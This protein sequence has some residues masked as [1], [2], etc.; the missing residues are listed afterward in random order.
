FLPGDDGRRDRHR[1]RDD[2]LVRGGVAA[3]PRR[4]HR[5]RPGE[6]HHPL[7]RRVHGHRAPHRG[8]RQEPG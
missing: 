8:C 6:P 4:D 5:Q 1:P 3:R 2:L 7:L